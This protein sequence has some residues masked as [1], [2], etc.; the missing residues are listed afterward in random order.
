MS[1]LMM[2]IKT[3]RSRVAALVFGV[4]VLVILMPLDAQALPSFA[5]QTGQNCVACHAGGQFP[6][7]GRAHV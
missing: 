3:W 7:I 2:Q 1:F 4:A 6:E 5:R